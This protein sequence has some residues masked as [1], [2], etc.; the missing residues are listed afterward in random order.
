MAKYKINIPLK[1]L[2]DSIVIPERLEGKAA[3]NN[4]PAQ[5]LGLMENPI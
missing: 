4:L 3:L 2:M 5:G 1:K